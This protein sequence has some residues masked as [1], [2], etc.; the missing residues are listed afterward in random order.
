MSML[1]A[2]ETIAGPLNAAD[3][4]AQRRAAPS[5]PPRRVMPAGLDQQG[6]RA[7]RGFGR[8]PGFV[9]TVATDYGSADPLAEDC[10]ERHSGWGYLPDRAPEGGQHREP[11]RTV[12]DGPGLLASLLWPLVAV[13]VIAAAAVLAPAWPL[14]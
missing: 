7:C 10:A 14:G 13:A 1:A 3:L 5:W 12:S 8:A 9:D 11:S 4:D 2:P 6:R